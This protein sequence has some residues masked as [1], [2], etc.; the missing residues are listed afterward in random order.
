MATPIQPLSLPSRLV[1]KSPGRKDITRENRRSMVRK[2]GRMLTNLL[3]A[4][5][6]AAKVL[7]R[8]TMI[9][10]NNDSPVTTYKSITTANSVVH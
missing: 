1:T 7:L 8:L 3:A 5:F 2:A 10:A 9:E 4:A 6:S